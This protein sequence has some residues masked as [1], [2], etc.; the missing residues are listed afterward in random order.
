MIILRKKIL[1]RNNTYLQYQPYQ[2]S[3]GVAKRSAL[4]KTVGKWGYPTTTTSASTCTLLYTPTHICAHT[5]TDMN[6]CTLHTHQKK[7]KKEN[8][9]K[10]KLIFLI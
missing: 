5:D 10:G 7:K 4:L 8:L 6:T 3:L 2:G 1:E 9:V